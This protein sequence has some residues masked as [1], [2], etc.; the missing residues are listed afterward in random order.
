MT[1]GRARDE[2]M[3]RKLTHKLT[4]D[5]ATAQAIMEALATLDEETDPRIA[6]AIVSET[7]A[8]LAKA[9]GTTESEVRR[10][11]ERQARKSRAYK[12]LKRRMNI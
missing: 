5:P 1:R 3:D 11:C 8:K 6:E 12:S 2:E 7:I 10:R 9:L 4:H